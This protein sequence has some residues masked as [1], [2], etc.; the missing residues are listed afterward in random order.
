MQYIR[1]NDSSYILHTSKGAVTLNRTSFNFNKVKVML[2]KGTLQEYNLLPL[3]EPPELPDGVFELYM[4]Y[5]GR[6]YYKQTR[7]VEGVVKSHYYWVGDEYEHDMVS[8]EISGTA[9]F[10]GVYASIKD[11]MFDYPEHFI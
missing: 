3:L 7:E 4:P 11:I 6:L 10:L 5:T 9:E 1:L 8:D 2:D